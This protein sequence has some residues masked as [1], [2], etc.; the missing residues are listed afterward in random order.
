MRRLGVVS[1]GTTPVFPIASL[2]SAHVPVLPTFFQEEAG[3][4]SK[5][6]EMPDMMKVL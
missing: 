3:V 2:N 6:W 1:V 5:L 4:T